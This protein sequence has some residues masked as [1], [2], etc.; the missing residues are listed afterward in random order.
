MKMPVSRGRLHRILIAASAAFLMLAAIFVPLPTSAYIPQAHAVRVDARAFAFEP[1][2]LSV[3]RGDT[4]TIHLES[5]DAVHGLYIDGY[6]VNLTAEPGA[7]A[8]A[9]FVADKEGKFKFRCAVACGALHP[10]MI[11]ELN[12]EPNTPLVRALLILIAGVIAALGLF[13]K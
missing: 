1:G 6:D 12:V 11:G 4:V 3:R 10:F 7:S 8:T 2:T 9:T 13:W 5:L